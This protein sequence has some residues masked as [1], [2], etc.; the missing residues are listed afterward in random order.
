M[1]SKQQKAHCLLVSY[2]SQGHINPMLQ[3][4]KR[5]EYHKVKA[6]LV[7]TRSFWK[8]ASITEATI[9]DSIA[10]EAISDGYDE[11][12][13][14][15]VK[16]SKIYVERFWKVG[17]VTLSE[18][19]HKLFN[20]DL[21][22]DCV[23]YDSFLPWVLDVAKKFGLVAAAFLT[24]PCFV[25][26]VYFHLHQGILKLPIKKETKIL[27]PALPE[28]EP[29][30]LPSFLYLQYGMYPIFW[31]LVVDTFDNIGKAD[32]LL[33]NTVYE[34]EPEAVD[35]M[36]RMW[37]VKT[38]GPTVPSMFLDKKIQDDQD[39]GISMFKPEN[40]LCMNWLHHKPK[41]SVIY[42]SFGSLANLS[43]DQMEEIAWGLTQ[44]E[45]YFLWV[46]RESEQVKLPNNIREIVSADKGL[47]VTWCPQLKVL[48]H[49]AVGCFVTHCGWNSTLEAL[50]SGVP[51][52][53]FP[54]WT[55][56]TTNLK[57]IV[58]V[59]KVGIRALVDEKGILRRETVRNCIKEVMGS[60]KGKEMKN[61]AIKWM[62]VVKSSMEEGGSSDKN[63]EEFITM[64]S[65]RPEGAYDVLR[66]NT[67]NGI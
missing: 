43:E 11:G 23:I 31:D 15:D 56:Q 51:M 45:N 27:L 49:E 5:L 33:P 36:R 4:C 10:L 66:E 8:Q 44:T 39:Y 24:Q 41:A 21:P 22:V 46:V 28:L 64:I 17:P 30:D 58:D 32:W 1:A 57:Y 54:Q 16:N 18:L 65:E 3:F 19:L 47:I 67:R 13:D 14:Q 40:D 26:S 53:G 52:I 6:T 42:V 35:L 48:S 12:A 37:P 62:S 7:T 50:S 9:S 59:W 34:L 2:P 25:N 63:I 60:E 38:I 20:S 55:D 61:N 29:P